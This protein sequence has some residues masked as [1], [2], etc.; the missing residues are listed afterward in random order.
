VCGVTCRLVIDTE[1]MLQVSH[2]CGAQTT[3]IKGCQEESSLLSVS[4]GD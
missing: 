2:H 1:M 4:I 3:R